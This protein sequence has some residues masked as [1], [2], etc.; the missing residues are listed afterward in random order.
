MTSKNS[1]HTEEDTKESFPELCTAQVKTIS[2]PLEELKTQDGLPS[3]SAVSSL[4]GPP[5][6]ATNRNTG[7]LRIIH[8]INS[9]GVGGAERGTL[10]VMEGLDAQHFDQ[11]LCTIRGADPQLAYSPLLKDRLLMAGQAKPGFQFLLFQLVSIFRNRKPHIVHS[12]NWGAIEAVLA[13]RIAGVP[14]VIHSEHGYELDMLSGLPLRRRALRRA[15]YPMCDAV[16]TV[17]RQLQEYHGAQVGISPKQ[18]RVIPNGV[19]TRLYAPDEYRRQQARE[20]FGFAPEHFVLGSVGRLVPIKGHDTMLRA[21]EVLLERNK[22]VRLLIVGAGPELERLRSYVE[23]SPLLKNRVVFAGAISDVAECYHAMDVFVLP[24]ICEGMSNT[25]LEGMAS[26]LPCVATNVGGNPELVSHGQEGFLFSP[27]DVSQ[28]AG[29][30]Q[31]I[32][33]DGILRARLA[34]AARQRAVSCF[35]LER[36]MAAYTNLYCELAERRG[37]QTRN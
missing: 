29:F 17:S 19:D 3:N 6:A 23:S 2:Q 26:G 15:C 36:M 24:S 25:L 21:G 1:N 9:L 34:A 30:V 10:K 4:A 12:R 8:V 14:V 16:F 27:G 35:S 11:N 31:Q 7:S 32:D 33:N 5:A 22:N 13:G 18:I 20:R 28:L 37:V